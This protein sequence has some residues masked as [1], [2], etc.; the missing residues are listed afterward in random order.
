L[1]V[2]NLFARCLPDIQSDRQTD[3]CQTFAAAVIPLLENENKD[4]IQNL[5]RVDSHKHAFGNRKISNDCCCAKEGIKDDT[6][7]NQNE[8]T[9]NYIIII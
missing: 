3:T 8:F 2:N 5:V 4:L 9:K 1:S 6:R 7:R